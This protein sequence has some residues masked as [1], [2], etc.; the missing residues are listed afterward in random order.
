[1]K[2]LKYTTEIDT[3]ALQLNFKTDHEQRVILQDIFN[4]LRDTFNSYID[5]VNYTVGS[6]TKIKYK[7]YCNNRTV[8]SFITGYSH[9][10]YF[11]KIRFAGLKTYDIVVDNTSLNYL[12]VTVAYINTKR[13]HWNLA[14][15]DIAIDIPFVSFDHLLAICTSKTSTQYHIPGEIQPILP[16]EIKTTFLK[17]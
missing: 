13:F 4:R 7:I 15:L 17:V 3:L 12:L 2:Q 8:L 5:L 1:M 10:K 11:I 6:I 16:Q 14:E 9:N